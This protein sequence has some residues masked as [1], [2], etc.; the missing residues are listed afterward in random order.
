M[1]KE[2]LGS[3]PQRF[4]DPRREAMLEPEEV[5]PILRLNELGWGA[6]RIAQELGISRNTA[7]EYIAA[8]GWTAYRQPRRKKADAAGSESS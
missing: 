6:K 4:N 5:S 8:A 1:Q 3:G 2:R 7:K